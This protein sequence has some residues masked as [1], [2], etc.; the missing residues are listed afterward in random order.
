[1]V[2]DDYEPTKNCIIAERI[3]DRIALDVDDWPEWD[4]S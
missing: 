1:M 4:G 2:G 3:M